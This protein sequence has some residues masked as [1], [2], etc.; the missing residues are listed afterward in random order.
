VI[1]IALI[2]VAWF[3]SVVIRFSLS[4]KREFLAVAGSWN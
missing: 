3:L 1:A 4:R 2:A